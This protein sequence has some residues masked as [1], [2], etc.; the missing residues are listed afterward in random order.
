MGLEEDF[1]KASLGG[2]LFGFCLHAFTPLPFGTLIFTF[3][4][5]GF[6]TA[7]ISENLERRSVLTQW[8]VTASAMIV[9]LISR[10][11]LWVISG[12]L[13]PF[14]ASVK[15]LV[16]TG[17]ITVLFSPVFISLARTVKVK[18]ARMLGQDEIRRHEMKYRW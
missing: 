6:W 17:L 5:T 10:G 9:T 8:L 7:L 13:P 4:L 2:A 18:I 1:F 12:T 14:Q 11:F 15:A 3:A 16:V